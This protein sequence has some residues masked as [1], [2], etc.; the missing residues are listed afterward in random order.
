[1]PPPQPPQAAPRRKG[2]VARTVTPAKSSSES[3]TDS[4]DSEDNYTP[5]VLRARP[6]PAPRRRLSVVVPDAPPPQPPV[7]EVDTPLVDGEQPIIDLASSISSLESEQEVEIV[8][9]LNIAGEDS[10]PEP[11]VLV[12][13]QSDGEADVEL[14]VSDDVPDDGASVTPVTARPRRTR[15]KPAWMDDTVYQFNTSQQHEIEKADIVKN[16]LGYLMSK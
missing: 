10:D 16:M 9:E 2:P 4:S 5:P 11:S 14:A 7:D 12:E 8:H 6:V 13:D 3:S 15:R 1:M